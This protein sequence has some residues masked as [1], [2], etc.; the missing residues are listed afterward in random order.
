MG[1]ISAVLWPLIFFLTKHQNSLLDGYKCTGKWTNCKT[2]VFS[3][4]VY[5]LRNA[6]D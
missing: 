1:K 4:V 3:A 2:N 5:N 6:E